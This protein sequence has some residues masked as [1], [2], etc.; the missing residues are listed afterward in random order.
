MNIKTE[1]PKN[2]VFLPIKPRCGTTDTFIVL[3]K[4]MQCRIMLCITVI[5]LFFLTLTPIKSELLK[6][7]KYNVFIY[8]QLPASF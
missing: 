3:L 5:R 1:T 6:Y 2:D 8:S 7:L 4:R